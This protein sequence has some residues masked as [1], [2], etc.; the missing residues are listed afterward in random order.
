MMSFYLANLR[1]Y[2]CGSGIPPN[3]YFF[4]AF[5]NKITIFGASDS[6][7][8]SCLS[9]EGVSILSVFMANVEIIE[10]GN[11]ATTQAMVLVRT[12]N[13]AGSSVIIKACNFLFNNLFSGGVI[14]IFNGKQSYPLNYTHAFIYS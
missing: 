4:Y 13:L 11:T 3:I 7:A 5:L 1:F 14:S 10:S 12:P 6:T 8:N 2:S 9:F